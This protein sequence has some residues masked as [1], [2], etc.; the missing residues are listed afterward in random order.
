MIKSVVVSLLF[1]ITCTFATD[2]VY[3][4]KVFEPEAFQ[5]NIQ[6]SK[7]FWFV[8]FYDNEVNELTIAIAKKV[9]Q[10][11]IETASV[12]C[13][14]KINKKV[15]QAANVNLMKNGHAFRTYYEPPQLNPYSNKLFR[16]F[17]AFDGAIE[18]RTLEKFIS[19]AYSD[20]VKKLSTE[21]EFQGLAANSTGQVAILFSEKDAIS[22][23]YKSVAFACRAYSGLKSFAQIHKGSSA[24]DEKFEIS[25]Y[26]TLL[27]AHTDGTVKTFSGDMKDRRAMIDWCK[28]LAPLDESSSANL[29][30]MSDSGKVVRRT[31][32]LLSSLPKNVIAATPSTFASDIWAKYPISWT[33]IVEDVQ[34]ESTPEQDKALKAAISAASSRCDGA[35][36][37]VLMV[38]SDNNTISQ[39]IQDVSI[40]EFG[41]ALCQRNSSNMDFPYIAVIPHG[42]NRKKMQKN[43]QKW[44]F[45][46]SDL[47]LAIKR[48]GE[49]LP[50]IKVAQLSEASL[51]DFLQLAN[52]QMKIPLLLLTDRD[53]GNVPILMRNLGLVVASG[54]AT[55][56][57]ESA[58][59]EDADLGLNIAHL[60]M[61]SKP[62]G[63]LLQNIG[64]GSLRLPVLVAFF[65]GPP[66]PNDDESKMPQLQVMAYNPELSGPLRIYS[67]RD[68]A[69]QV[70]RS[71]QLPAPER[72]FSSKT[73]D[74]SSAK[75]KEPEP[76][77]EE[78]EV[79]PEDHLD[80]GIYLMSPSLVIVS[81]LHTV[82]ATVDSH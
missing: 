5:E 46:L 45:K 9:S 78:P 43:M 77:E 54:S 21:E 18:A 40:D 4:V 49:S 41:G 67:A 29:S 11:G 62:S 81:P 48:S 66:D 63:Q 3:T 10:Y 47:D 42:S 52:T 12:N 65:L 24:L 39:P 34:P 72:P 22:M 19:R 79:L 27:V 35:M 37:P 50:D 53:S 56:A 20:L 8:N 38:C 55:N 15:C 36:Q 25:D 74:S 70:F 1:C 17:S 7:D 82:T 80:E 73:K 75:K 2:I 51:G 14:E 26:P 44:L 31:Q 60:G 32:N 58:I 28:E 30:E 76:V 23:H 69:L 33:V 64:G 6:E 57:E 13:S 68:F 59:E 16:S 61:I 71:S